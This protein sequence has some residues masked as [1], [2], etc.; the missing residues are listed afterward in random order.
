VLGAVECQSAEHNEA[1]AGTHEMPR[2]H[3]NQVTLPKRCPVLLLPPEV[4]TVTL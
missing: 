4:L 2:L 3:L 1:I